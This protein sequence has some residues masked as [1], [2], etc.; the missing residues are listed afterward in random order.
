MCRQTAG[1]TGA[2][3]VRHLPREAPAWGG[4]EVTG[5]NLR[6][7]CRTELATG[8]ASGKTPSFVPVLEGR[9]HHRTPDRALG[10]LP[11]LE[12]KAWGQS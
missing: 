4:A 7:G 5:G 8:E 12:H 2:D 1:H 9:G 11:E 10:P 6:A 3:G